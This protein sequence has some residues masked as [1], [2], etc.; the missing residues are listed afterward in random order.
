MKRVICIFSL[1][2]FIGMIALPA[3]NNDKASTTDK[4]KGTMDIKA[5]YFHATNRC[6]T[7]KAVEAVTKETIEQYYGSKVPFI[8][9]N[10][11]KDKDN[12]LVKKYEIS[13]QTLL[14]IKGEKAVNL[15]NDGFLN[16]RTNPDKFKNKIK[17]T[18]DSM[19]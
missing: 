18:I 4:S 19:M 17:A 2:L 9:I 11:E 10:R 12:P 3:Q 16:A 6:V 5:Y 7:C 14:I 1:M 13:G 8:V 15:T